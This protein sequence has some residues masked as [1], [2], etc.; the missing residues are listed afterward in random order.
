MGT[1]WARRRGGRG[2]GGREVSSINILI[3]KIEQPFSSR[4]PFLQ[5]S[6][7]PSPPHPKVVYDVMSVN[8]TAVVH[9]PFLQLYGRIEDE[10]VRP[11]RAEAAYIQ[12]GGGSRHYL[13][14]PLA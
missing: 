8:G 14:P 2:K 10:V 6:S 5:T 12:E 7:S 4:E 9:E 13:A 11:R 3:I 1:K